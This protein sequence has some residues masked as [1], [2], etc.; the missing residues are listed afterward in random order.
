MT[1]RRQLRVL[2]HRAGRW[3]GGRRW[4]ASIS[5]LA[6]MGV[7][8]ALLVLVVSENTVNATGAPAKVAA[9]STAKKG[10]AP[11][12]GVKT[13]TPTTKPVG[14]TVPLGVYAG[15]G[16]PVAATAFSA[17]AGAPV[18]YAFD[19]IDGSTWQSISD[20]MWFVQRWSGSNF[21]MIWGVPMLPATGATLAAGSSGAFT[22][23]PRPG[24]ESGVG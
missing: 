5:L 7:T 1:L 8:A 3:A 4:L 14:Q 21:R 20:P 17:D 15:P 13:T 12:S 18:P 19:Y 23:S 2:R 16:A 11:K 24:W 10:T 22:M 9:P 6:A